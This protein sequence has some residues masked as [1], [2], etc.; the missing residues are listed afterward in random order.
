MGLAP[1][2]VERGPGAGGH[3]GFLHF[4][5]LIDIFELCTQQIWIQHTLTHWLPLEGASSP[6]PFAKDFSNLKVIFARR[7]FT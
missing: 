1:V 3:I 2:F 4:E 7:I 5:A 6:E